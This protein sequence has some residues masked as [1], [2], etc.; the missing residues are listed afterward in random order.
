MKKYFGIIVILL[1]GCGSSVNVQPG[2]T[3]IVQGNGVQYTLTATLDSSGHSF[4]ASVATT[5]AASVSLPETLTALSNAGYVGRAHLTVGATFCDYQS[6]TNGVYVRQDGSC[7]T[8]T[9]DGAVSIQVGDTVSLEIE[10]VPTQQ[11]AVEAVIK[12]TQD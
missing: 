10:G 5:E 9:P 7:N 3:Q 2:A 6:D 4:P 12:G 1:S 8:F 11:T